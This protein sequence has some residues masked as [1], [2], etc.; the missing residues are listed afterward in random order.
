MYG[1]V[2]TA[3]GT[4]WVLTRQSLVRGANRLIQISQLAYSSIEPFHSS[5]GIFTSFGVYSSRTRTVLVS[6]NR[7]FLGRSIHLFA[8]SNP[9]LSYTYNRETCMAEFLVFRA[10][11]VIQFPK[12]HNI[13]KHWTNYQSSFPEPLSNLNR[14]AHRTLKAVGF[15]YLVLA[16]YW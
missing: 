14:N 7:L 3:Q 11:N 13:L 2:I 4:L 10:L 12:S 5:N 6:M 16:A 8:G 15:K 1:M 9:S